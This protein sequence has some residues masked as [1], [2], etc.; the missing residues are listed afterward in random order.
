ML[1][2]T[3]SNR[4]KNH[5]ALIAHELS[6]LN[7]NIAAL[8]EDH[9]PGEGSSQ[10]QDTGYTLFWS[11]K[12]ET[13]GRLSNVGFMVSTSTA[14]RLENLPNGHSDRMMSMHLPLKNKQYATL[15]SMYSPTLQ[16][17]PTEKDNFHLEPHSHLQSTPSND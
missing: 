3:D 8:R 10:E 12:T 11:G 14:S 7:I 16:A 6:R 9:F 2:A 17:E 13:E 15:F 4:P 1:D 5:S